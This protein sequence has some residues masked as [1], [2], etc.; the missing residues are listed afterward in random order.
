MECINLDSIENQY[1]VYYLCDFILVFMFLRLMFLARSI[2]NYSIYTDAYSKKLCRNT[3]GFTS[4]N[5]FT[6]K[7]QM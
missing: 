5:R 4:G 6:L 7:V 1:V 2:M 3:Y